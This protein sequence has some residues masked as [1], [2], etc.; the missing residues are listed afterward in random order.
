MKLEDIKEARVH[1][2]D[3]AMDD[4]YDEKHAE[5]TNRSEAPYYV[6]WDGQGLEW[7]SATDENDGPESGRGRYKNKFAG[8]I[9]AINIPDYETAKK[10]A[11]EL[12][13]SYEDHKFYDPSVYNDYG[14]DW[15]V[16][17]YY[18]SYVRSMKDMD[19]MDKYE[20]QHY[21]NRIKNYAK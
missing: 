2:N 9:V 17:E 14:H 21:A 3:P 16:S 5:D 19:E 18:G 4:V 13:K 11:D 12:E 20:V 15:W 7:Y 6:G 1:R 8:G 10:V